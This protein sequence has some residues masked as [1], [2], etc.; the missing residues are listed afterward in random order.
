MGCGLEPERVAGSSKAW[1]GRAADAG[2]PAAQATEATPG[3]HLPV[4]L[5]CRGWDTSRGLAEEVNN[6]F[7]LSTPP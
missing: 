5:G 4:A 3:K 7:L 2:P 1:A 6:S